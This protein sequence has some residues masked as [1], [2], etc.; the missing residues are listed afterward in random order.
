M[1]HLE[2]TQ[3]QFQSK[4]NFAALS[5][6]L[7]NI[8]HQYASISPLSPVA[9]R[10]PKPWWYPKSPWL[11]ILSHGHPWLGWLGVHPWLGKPPMIYSASSTDFHIFHYIPIILMRSN[12]CFHW[13]SMILPSYSMPILFHSATSDSPRANQ[14]DP[15]HEVWLEHSVARLHR[16]LGS[17]GQWVNFLVLPNWI[18]R[19]A[20]Q[21]LLETLSFRTRVRFSKRFPKSF[22]FAFSHRRATVIDHRWSS[23]RGS[24]ILYINRDVECR[25]IPSSYIALVKR[26]KII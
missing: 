12:R 21:S 6:A 15:V 13:Q 14:P 3:D 5:V 16:G 11:S 23:Q 1:G 2:V 8:S 26:H 17:W 24:P 25:W 19:D 22:F 9:S 4:N 18:Q 20:M 7:C 10:F